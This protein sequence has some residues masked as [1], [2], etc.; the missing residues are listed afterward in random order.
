[1]TMIQWTG[2]MPPEFV[3][4]STMSHVVVYRQAVALCKPNSTNV[5]LQQMSKLLTTLSIDPKGLTRP[6]NKC[7][8]KIV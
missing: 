8:V 3:K 2:T 7:I 5:C 1:M 6:V 4:L